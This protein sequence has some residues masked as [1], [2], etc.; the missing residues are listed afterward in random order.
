[1][2]VNP[3][4]PD[5]VSEVIGTAPYAPG[6]TYDS[7]YFEYISEDGSTRGVVMAEHQS[8]Y[9][10]YVTKLVKL[11][12]YDVIHAHDWLTFRAALAA[13][14]A[15]GAPLF[16]HIHSTEFDRA[17]GSQATRSFMR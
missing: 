10:D 4:V 2:K 8:N 17:G 11:N 3:A 13:K 15:S 16:V 5:D 9:A 7:Q 14:Q 1:M 6:S 12:E